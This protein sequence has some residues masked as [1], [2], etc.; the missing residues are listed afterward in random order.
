M[1]LCVPELADPPSVNHLVVGCWLICWGNFRTEKL[2]EHG[3]P[4][5]YTLGRW[6]QKEQ[7]LTAAWAT[8][9]LYL[10]KAK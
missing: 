1:S 6:R 4:A 7:E 9:M 10:K 3:N 2:A 8:M 5:V